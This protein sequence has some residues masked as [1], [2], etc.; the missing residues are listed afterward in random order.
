MSTGR[1]PVIVGIDFGFTCMSND[2]S[3]PVKRHER[4][5]SKRTLN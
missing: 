1:L 3:D 4:A 5:R 2:C